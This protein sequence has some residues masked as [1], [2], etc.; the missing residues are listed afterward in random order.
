M[1]MEKVPFKSTFTD[2]YEL[3]IGGS[4][5][6]KI[7]GFLSWSECYEKF[8]TDIFKSEDIFFKPILIH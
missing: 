1:K 4:D 8:V 7:L 3:F 5:L 6:R 2:M